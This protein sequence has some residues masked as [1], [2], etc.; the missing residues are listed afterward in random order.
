MSPPILNVPESAAL[1]LDMSHPFAWLVYREISVRGRKLI[2]LVEMAPETARRC[3]MASY[4]FNQIY[5]FTTC[6]KLCGHSFDKSLKIYFA[7]D[8]DFDWN[9]IFGGS[10]SFRLICCTLQ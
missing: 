4:H 6:I 9:K 7:T 10:F 8:R 2:N 1:D 3:E 5:E